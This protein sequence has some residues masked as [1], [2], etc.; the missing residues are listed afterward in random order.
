MRTYNGILWETYPV[1][2]RAHPRPTTPTLNVET[3]EASEKALFTAAGVNLKDFK[4]FLRRNNIAVLATR[5]VTSRD[6]ADEQQPYNLQVTGT[7]HKT[8]NPARSTPLY[9]VKHL[10][11]VQMDMLRGIGG[12]ATPK[13]GRRGIAQT[14]Y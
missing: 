13:A 14:R 6:D 3:V 1:E 2:V 12:T 5:D 9:N 11:F 8:V 7:T 10:Q 4:K